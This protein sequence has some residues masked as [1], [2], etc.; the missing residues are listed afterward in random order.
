MSVLFAVRKGA[1]I[2]LHESMLDII[3]VVAANY[4]PIN[5]IK[6]HSLTNLTRLPHT[7]RTNQVSDLDLCFGTDDRSQ[8]TAIEEDV[9]PAKISEFL[10]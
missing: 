5:L 6:K 7:D 8:L 9:D 10:R 1:D 4:L 3:K 2:D